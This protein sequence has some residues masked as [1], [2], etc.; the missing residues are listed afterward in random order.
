MISSAFRSST[1]VDE[2]YIESMRNDS[3][4]QALRLAIIP[5]HSMYAI[6]TIDPSNHP[7]VGIYGSPME[8]LG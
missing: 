3:S 6:Y 8:C 1:L 7:N 4:T 5:K 2:M